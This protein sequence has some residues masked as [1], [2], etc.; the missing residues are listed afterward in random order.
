MSMG[1][2]VDALLGCGQ[3]PENVQLARIVSV[4]CVPGSGLGVWH[5]RCHTSARPCLI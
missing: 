4:V 2:G 5:M 3:V 1:A